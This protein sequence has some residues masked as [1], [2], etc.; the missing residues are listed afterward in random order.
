MT[1]TV[2]DSDDQQ[3]LFSD[4]RINSPTAVAIG[5]DG[6]L[7]VADA[8]SHRVSRI[9]GDSGEIITLAGLGEAAFNGDLKPAVSAALNTPNG[10]AVGAN[11]DI[12]IADSGNNRIRMISAATSRFRSSAG[13]AS[14]AR[15]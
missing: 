4:W 13:R 10:I 1:A 9:N 3:V 12:Y 8:R 11:G 15:R 6:D 7:Y 14:I 5:P 2:S